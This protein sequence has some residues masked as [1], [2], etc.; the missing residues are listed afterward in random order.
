VAKLED[1]WLSR[2]LGG[3][4]GRWVAKLLARLLATVALCVRI[5]TSLK[6]TKVGDISKGEAKILWPSPK[7]YTKKYAF[8]HIYYLPNPNWELRVYGSIG[9]GNSA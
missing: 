4:V 5:Q 9:C 3:Y 1:G 2:E 7:K 8:V 6:N